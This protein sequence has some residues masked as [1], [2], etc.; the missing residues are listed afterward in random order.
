MPA[1]R[2]I[3]FPVDFSE[4]SKAVCTY[5]KSFAEQFHAKLTLMNV[6]QIP[7]GMP[8]G[9]DP[10]YPVMFDFPA[11]EP[12][13]RE[14]LKDYC[15]APDVE[16]VVKLGDPA[17]DIADYA[18]G[19]GVDLIMLPTHG[20][21]KFRSLLLGSVTSKVLHDAA[22]A[23][24]TAPHA[25][26]PAMQQHWPCRNVLVAVD[27]GVEQAPVLRRAAE[28]ARELGAN[29]RLVHAVPTAER[30]AGETGGDEFSHFLMRMAGED[31][32]KLQAAAGTDFEAS[33]VAGGVG[34]VVRQTAETLRADLLVMGR[35]VMHDTFGRLRSKSYDII[36]QSPCPVLS[37]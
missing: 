19:N 7:P 5:V 13:V 24:W 17:I 33:V 9:I 6:V 20:Y 30:Q 34:P 35:G 10:S 26:D 28:L 36:R 4:R 14:V 27:R 12:Q 31:M 1:F 37:L 22:C 29:V 25:A 2:H 15:D 11:I 16:R 23:V 18:G 3:L 21:G 8:G 32:A